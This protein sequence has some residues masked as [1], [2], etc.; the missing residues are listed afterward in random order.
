M[1][2]IVK[3][4]QDDHRVT[5]TR[6]MYAKWNYFLWNIRLNFF[7]IKLFLFL[8][9]VL[10]VTIVGAVFATIFWHSY[11]PDDPNHLSPEQHTKLVMLFVGILPT[12]LYIPFVRTIFSSCFFV[13]EEKT[14]R[15]TEITIS[16]VGTKTSFYT[17]V[18]VNLLWFVGFWVLL[19]IL[20]TFL[21]FICIQQFNPMFVFYWIVGLHINHLPSNFLYYG[22]ASKDFAA[23]GIPNV[24]HGINSVWW[25]CIL[26][27]VN[28]M[29]NII[30]MILLCVAVS[31]ALT[32][33][34]GGIGVFVFLFIFPSILN[35]ILSTILQMDVRLLSKILSF[36]PIFSS[37]YLNMLL[38]FT[39]SD[40]SV[41][42]YMYLAP[43]VVLA[44][45]GLLIY[46]SR[47][48][49][50]RAIFNDGLIKTL[51][52]FRQKPKQFKNQQLLA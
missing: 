18:L 17:K 23:A 22:A 38:I 29:G 2:E 44:I 39:S 1:T 52:T 34:R 5:R 10:I 16:S 36:I 6:V 7:N 32:S 43:F 50:E 31:S 45:S 8:A 49:Y 24:D 4:E 19:F 25:Y 47:M 48:F 15:A 28:T 42:I 46:P 40:G 41:S 12:L 3:K 30:L 21:S 20:L 11:K 13:L 26:L 33:I 37:F 14:S 9:I 51:K 27:G 35:T